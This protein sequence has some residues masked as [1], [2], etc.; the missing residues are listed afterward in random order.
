MIDVVTSVDHRDIISTYANTL[1]MAIISDMKG[2]IP[3]YKEDHAIILAA[4]Y[5]MSWIMDQNDYRKRWL[6]G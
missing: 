4:S 1:I 3:I 2:G 6:N 5:V